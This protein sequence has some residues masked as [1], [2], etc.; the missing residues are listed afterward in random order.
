M[1]TTVAAATPC[2]PCIMLPTSHAFSNV[3]ISKE[4]FNYCADWCEV[5]KHGAFPDVYVVLHILV[6]VRVSKMYSLR[7]CAPMSIQAD[8]NSRLIDAPTPTATCFEDNGLHSRTRRVDEKW[9]TS[10]Q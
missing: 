6:F 9:P 2:L 7:T 8:V 1:L 4:L 5:G 10:H 3:P